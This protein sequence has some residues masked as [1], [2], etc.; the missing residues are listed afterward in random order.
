MFSGVNDVNGRR[1]V[2]FCSTVRRLYWRT[3]SVVSMMSMIED[4]YCFVAQLEDFTEGHVQWYALMMSMIED[5]YCSVGNCLSFCP[6]YFGHCIVCPS[7]IY[8]FRLPLW[9]LQTF[10]SIILKFYY[11]STS[12][13]HIQYCLLWWLMG[14]LSHQYFNHG[15][16]NSY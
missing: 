5:V 2:L 11:I 6:F 10:R 16:V 7:L 9:Y 15:C 13:N 3:C 4:V 12:S 14:E 1:F 8:G